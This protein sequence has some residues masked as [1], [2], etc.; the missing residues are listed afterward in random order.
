MIKIWLTPH[1]K[2]K[3]RKKYIGFQNKLQTMRVYTHLS[4]ILITF[5]LS[6]WNDTL[7][8]RD[9]GLII[10]LLVL[11]DNVLDFCSPPTSVVTNVPLVCCWHGAILIFCEISLLPSSK[12]SK[13]AMGTS[14]SETLQNIPSMVTIYADEL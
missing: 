10:F 12:L 7:E 3:Q 1:T 6:S 2:G 5:S 4:S 8:G 11:L 9:D 13:F 14:F